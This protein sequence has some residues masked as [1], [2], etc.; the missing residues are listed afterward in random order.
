MKV[1][2]IAEIMEKLAPKKF[3]VPNDN[4][5]IIVG[6]A[7]Q[8][9]DTILL[10]LDV[11][12]GVVAEAA[13]L[14]AQMI[15]SHHPIMYK[16]IQQITAATPQG[17]TIRALIKNDISMFAAHINLDVAPGGLCAVMAEKIG[18][19]NMTVLDPL[20]CDLYGDNVGLGRIGD[21][22]PMRLTELAAHV[23]KVLNVRALKYAGEDKIVSRVATC[24]GMGASLI[25]LAIE[26]GADVYIS[27]DFTMDQSRDCAA[28]GTAI[29]DAGHHETEVTAKE[30][31]Y[32]FFTKELGDKVKLYTSK[33]NT[34]VYDVIL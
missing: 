11:D 13:S 5:G 16:P 12:C 10:T 18:L 8:E 6:D 1:K 3:S 19:S 30:V 25:P 26:K 15:V 28:A 20:H 4:I 14:G 21:I 29:I 7:E 17:R 27:G 34:N 33:A 22:A 31:F 9:V 24:C 32:N 23:K 2:D